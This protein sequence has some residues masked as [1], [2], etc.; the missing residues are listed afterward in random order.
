MCSR[1]R[2]L[3]V[4]IFPQL[5]SSGFFSV[6]P[7]FRLFGD[8]FDVLSASPSLVAFL[9]PMSLD[10]FWLSLCRDGSEVVFWSCGG[11]SPFRGR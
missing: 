11:W 1:T 4:V 8:S 9:I 6:F 7:L 10:L 2:P 5:V 3:C